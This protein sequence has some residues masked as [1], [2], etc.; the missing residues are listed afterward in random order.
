MPSWIHKRSARYGS[1]R[2][3]ITWWFLLS[4]E[5]PIF[6]SFSHL[7][8][9]PSFSATPFIRACRWICEKKRREMWLS[10]PF[11][12]S[13]P[14]NDW[15]AA[16]VVW[17]A[18]FTVCRRSYR[19]YHTIVKTPKEKLLFHSALTGQRCE[20]WQQRRVRWRSRKLWAWVPAWALL[21]VLERAQNFYCG[22]SRI[23]LC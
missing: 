6:F 19:F 23:T 5:H 3:S 1:D 16:L 8:L 21:A 14:R 4:S 11:L 9:Q 12:P 20:C 7:K 13:L 17:S 15:R 10:D 22:C 2:L 18:V